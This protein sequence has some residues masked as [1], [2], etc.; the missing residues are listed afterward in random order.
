MY[1]YMHRHAC[2]HAIRAVYPG[3]LYSLKILCKYLKEFLSDQK[4]VK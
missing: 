1:M 3:T 2:M 4:V